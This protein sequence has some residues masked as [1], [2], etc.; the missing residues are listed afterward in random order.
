MKSINTS[1]EHLLSVINNIIDFSKIED[2]KVVLERHEFI[3]G[4]KVEDLL[5]TF[6]ILVK[7]KKINL[8]LENK[9]KGKRYFGDSY[10]LSQ[11][12]NN[13][14]S[15]AIKFT[16]N[17][18]VEIKLSSKV[19]KNNQEEILIEVID[20]G[21]GVPKDA[22]SKLFDAYIQGDQST[23]RQFGG[24]GLGLS[25]SKEL[26]SLFNGELG[27]KENAT[28]GSTFFFKFPLEVAR[29]SVSKVEVNKEVIPLLEDLKVLIVD[30]EKINRSLLNLYFKKDRNIEIQMAVN[31]LEAFEKFKSLSP[32]IVL[33][34]LHM[35]VMD[36]EESLKKMR[37]Y[38]KE[39][40]LKPAIIFMVSANT[41]SESANSLKEIGADSYLLKP[42]SSR[43]LKSELLKYI[44]A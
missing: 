26:A 21:I 25:I 11:I 4:E 1:S 41:L 30:D 28:K 27:F 35:P 24:T 12:V 37:Q 33:L 40:N 20:N 36:G 34:D 43:K 2:S 8:V 10:R 31:G 7:T 44:K 22:Q 16:A 39:N 13:L 14:I 38:E 29:G 32:D 15:N 3:L 18:K 19:I 9:L 6:S 23:T 5:N 42:I 17:G